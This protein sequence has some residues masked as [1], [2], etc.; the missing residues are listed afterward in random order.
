MIRADKEIIMTTN[1]TTTPTAAKRRTSQRKN[2][3][4]LIG[5]T[6][7]LSILVTGFGQGAGNDD[8]MVSG[9]QTDGFPKATHHDVKCFA[10]TRPLGTIIVDGWNLLHT[11]D[12]PKDLE[13]CVATYGPSVT[14]SITTFSGYWVH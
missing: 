9:D 10:D 5:I 2:I 1:T 6:L 4:S 11:T 7:L 12:D 8:G 14:H 3:F 13:A